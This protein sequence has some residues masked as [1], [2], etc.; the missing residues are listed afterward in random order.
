MY[1]NEAL[2]RRTR[3]TLKDSGDTL[4]ALL[5][6]VIGA[7]QEETGTTHKDTWILAYVAWSAVHGLA[8]LLIEEQILFEV[9]VEALIHQTMCTVVDGIKS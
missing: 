1:G 7:F 9:N 4:F 8:S 6:K 3:P 5:R 2:N